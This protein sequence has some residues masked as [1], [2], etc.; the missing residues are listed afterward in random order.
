MPGGSCAR[1][2][3]LPD[4]IASI[5][6]DCRRATL[7]TLNADGTIASVPVGFALVGERVITQVDDK[8]KEGRE[9]ARVANVRREP[10]ATLLFDRWDEDWTRLGWVMVKGVASLEPPREVPELLARYPQ[11][12]AAPPRGPLLVVDPRS[13][14]WWTWR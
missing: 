14:R 13:I 12:H 6:E 10:R 9:L 4:A 3:D 2:A 11:Y 5:V 8:P 1:L 7:S